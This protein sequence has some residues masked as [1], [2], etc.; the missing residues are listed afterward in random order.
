MQG[1]EPFRGTDVEEKNG[2]EK[3]PVKGKVKK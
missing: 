1:G 3:H 2:E